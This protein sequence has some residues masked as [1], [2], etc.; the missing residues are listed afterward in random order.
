MVNN[1]L[2]QD[3]MEHIGITDLQIH[4]PKQTAR[5]LKQQTSKGN[6]KAQGRTDQEQEA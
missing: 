2:D 1:L 3:K 6:Q 4:G 5:R